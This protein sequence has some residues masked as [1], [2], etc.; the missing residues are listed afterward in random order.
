VIGR[1]WTWVVA[2]VA[3]ASAS[4]LVAHSVQPLDTAG[5]YLVLQVIG[6]AALIAI[7]WLQWDRYALPVLPLAIVLVLRG[8]PITRPR[9]T[10]ALVLALA[11]VALV[12]VR[13]HLAYNR[14]LW[15]AV[16]HL[17]SIGVKPA[18]FDGGYVVNGWLQWAHPEQARRNAAGAVEVPWMNARTIPRYRISNQAR[19]PEG[20]WKVITSFAYTRWAGRS[21]RVY[22]LEQDAQSTIRATS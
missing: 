20:Q 21:G 12:G 19:P 6:H 8:G 2:L 15:A 10:A 5:T 1:G 16:G 17:Q 22:V 11:L 4:A 9:I 14:A 7:L 3:L 18:E 13:D